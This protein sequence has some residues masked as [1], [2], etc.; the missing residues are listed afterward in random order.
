M[1]E[2]VDLPAE[3]AGNHHGKGGDAKTDEHATPP[4]H[5]MPV[6]EGPP[7]SHLIGEHL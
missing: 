3:V 7:R 4:T 2:A 5:M 6:E 1:R